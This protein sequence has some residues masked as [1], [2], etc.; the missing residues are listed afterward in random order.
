MTIEAARA[1]AID[2]AREKGRADAA[3]RRCLPGSVFPIQREAY[4]E[5]YHETFSPRPVG[6]PRKDDQGRKDSCGTMPAALVA[7]SAAPVDLLPTDAA[8]RRG[9]AGRA[10]AGS[11]SAPAG[12]SS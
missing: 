2:R 9:V 5:G 3:R 11:S 4:L 8:L 12:V 6:R 10:T 1:D 7:G